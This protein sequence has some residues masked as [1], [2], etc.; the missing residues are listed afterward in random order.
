MDKLQDTLD[1][2][3]KGIVKV[4]VDTERGRVELTYDSITLTLTAPQVIGAQSEPQ[5]LE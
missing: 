4:N 1:W 5:N 2:F 3:F